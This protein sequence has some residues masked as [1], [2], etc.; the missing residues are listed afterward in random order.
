M[1]IYKP[2][3]KYKNSN[4]PWLGE[5]PEHWRNWKIAR[6]ANLIGS[7][8][9]PNSGNKEY[10][11]NGTIN[12]L[13]TGD[14][15]DSILKYCKRKVTKKAVEENSALKLFPKGTLSIAMYGATIG[16]VC[17]VD[18]DTTTNQ[19]CCNIVEGDIFDNK[20]L[21]YWFIGNKKHI[22][23]L[24]YGGG[25]PN[26]SQDVIKQLIVPS[27]KKQ[28]QTAIARF[29]D[30]KLA[31]I[32][33]FIRKKKQLIKLLNEQK[34]AIINQAVTKGLDP[35]AKMKESGIEWLGEIPEHWDVSKIKW[36]TPVKRGAS[37]RPIDDPI[38]FDED[39]EFGWVRI[40]DVTASERYL[41]NTTQKLSEL[42][43]SLSVKQFPGDLFLSIAG[44]VGKPIITK[45]KCCIHDGFVWFPLLQINKEFIYYI[46]TAGRCYLG[47]GKMGTQLNLNTDSVGG[48]TI[49]LPPTKEIDDIVEFLDLETATINTTISKIEKEIALVEEYKTAL[50]AEA[51]T[52]KIDVRGYE[53]PEVTEEE[54]YEE[55]EEEISITSEDA[56][57]Y[58]T[59]EE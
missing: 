2:Y 47:L 22:V 28:E 15:N 12:W 5:I 3:P 19:A 9:T 32:N 45:I 18:F 57:A 21:M 46:F 48:I 51:V 31:K 58:Q 29:L 11:E 39:G 40:A 55:I 49:P 6:G 37:P 25:Q 27:P 10:Y 54:T 4:I 56:E 41:E 43:S 33:R 53:V 17:I 38:Y 36:L 35:N 50:I 59:V 1:A 26:I 52:G 34:A 7:G 8:T 30:Y 16:K 44:S 14:F 20:F 42:G 24:S 23:N 13:N